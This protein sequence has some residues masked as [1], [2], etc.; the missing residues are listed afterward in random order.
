MYSLIK[1]WL[2]SLSVQCKDTQSD[3]KRR[4]W[5]E[6]KSCFYY[7]IN[8]A[9][10]RGDTI[11]PCKLLYSILNVFLLVRYKRVLNRKTFQCHLANMD[12][13]KSHWN[14]TPLLVMR[15]QIQSGLKLIMKNYMG[16]SDMGRC[17][18]EFLQRNS[19]L[20]LSFWMKVL[21]SLLYTSKL[22]SHQICYHM[23]ILLSFKLKLKSIC[24]LSFEKFF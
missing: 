5:N 22:F 8:M 6:N 3:L 18:I 21:H 12:H 1:W 10:E 16:F 19:T 11:I 17:M 24:S 9:M 20:N 7:Q 2:C 23:R 15:L 14:Q 13:K 4:S